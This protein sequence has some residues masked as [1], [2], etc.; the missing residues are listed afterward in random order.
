M[1]LYTGH[2]RSALSLTRPY[3]QFDTTN[4]FINFASNLGKVGE[5]A[6]AFQSGYGAFNLTDATTKAYAAIFGSAPTADKVSHLL[7]DAVPNGVGGSYEREDYFATYGL[8]GL[9]GQGTKAAM[10]GWLLGVAAQGDLGTYAKSDA[11][12][13]DVA[14]GKASFGVDLVGTYGKPEYVYHG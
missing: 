11:F 2:R 1:D 7:H 13:L 14:S 10:A 8:D 4:R 3:A 9:N 6:A 5:G 12:L